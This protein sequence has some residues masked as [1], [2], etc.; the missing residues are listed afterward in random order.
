MYKLGHRPQ[1]KQKLTAL[2][3]LIIAGL[4][5]AVI[6]ILSNYFQSDTTLSESEGI[7]R[8]VD[9]AAPATKKIDNSIFSFEIPKSWKS[10]ESKL[11]PAA[12]YTWHGV[13]KDESA[14]SLEIYVDTNPATMPVNRLLPVK[15]SGNRIVVGDSISD[16]CV[17]FTDSKK[18]NKQT[19]L[20]LAS[21]SGVKFYCDYSNY[22]RD[23]IGVSTAQA[24]NSIALDGAAAGSHKFFFVYTDHGALPDYSVISDIISSVRVH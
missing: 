15:A 18:A 21:W 4:I 1:H 6:W 24:I 13:G 9:V 3:I 2:I 14:R 17:D 12:Q 22:G 10:G 8:Q 16:N 5:I 11:L 19:G 23:V 7:V 20:L